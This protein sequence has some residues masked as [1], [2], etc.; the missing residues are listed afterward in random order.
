MCVDVQILLR[1]KI[2]LTPQI[3]S[4]RFIY[5]QADR[6]F[7]FAMGIYMQNNKLSDGQASYSLSA[8]TYAKPSA[9]SVEFKNFLADIEHL[10]T[11]ATSMTSED[12]TQ[13]KSK[14]NERMDSIKHSFDD[15]SESVSTK[16]RKSAAVTN[17]YVHE[18]P[19]VA[20]GAGAVVGLL[21]GFLASRRS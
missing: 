1:E 20:I 14:L 13:A 12:L 21:V 15:L 18:Q 10:I 9:V 19:W 6:L 11:E 4:Y 16:A 17:N 3:A 7:T 2:I 5:G 8:A